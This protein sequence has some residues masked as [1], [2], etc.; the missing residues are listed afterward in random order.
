VILVKGFELF[1]EETTL[2]AYNVDE[3]MLGTH[4]VEVSLIANGYY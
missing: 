4:E 3:T 2:V 1:V